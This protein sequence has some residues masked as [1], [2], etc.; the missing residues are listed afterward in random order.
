M[1]I[2]FALVAH[3][4]QRC[5]QVPNFPAGKFEIGSCP[6][7]A[8][9]PPN[10]SPTYTSAAFTDYITTLSSTSY[11]SDQSSSSTTSGSTD[12]GSV[13]SVTQPSWT[14]T[15]SHSASPTSSTTPTPGTSTPT[16]VSG[17]YK[18]P[19]PAPGPVHENNVT[20]FADRFCRLH[21]NASALFHENDKPM[22]GVG[23]PIDGV[24]YNYSVAWTTEGCLDGVI[25]Q[26]L[27]SEEDCRLIYHNNWKS[28]K[29]A[30][31]SREGMF[32]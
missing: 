26:Q 17:C 15:I 30:S 14:L 7:S 6:L 29:S 27:P 28:C 16:P 12:S 24:A 19:I 21:F 2:F 20:E 1:L 9:S 13:T 5:L 8:D 4:P 18:E 23:G 32:T 11:I 31:L 25:V 3:G 10:E 22:V